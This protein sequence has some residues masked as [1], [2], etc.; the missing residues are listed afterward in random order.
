MFGKRQ[1]KPK[2]L[3]EHLECLVSDAERR[4]SLMSAD[5]GG[6]IGEAKA[7]AAVVQ[8]LVSE[9]SILPVT[10]LLMLRDYVSSWLEGVRDN[11]YL[12]AILPMITAFTVML[13]APF[14]NQQAEVFAYILVPAGF[15]IYMLWRLGKDSK[16]FKMDRAQGELLLTVICGLLEGRYLQPTNGILEAATAKRAQD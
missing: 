7:R 6:L 3:F 2:D 13:L 10:D 1:A 16:E 15:W 8:S 4:V 14:M 11:S 5:N 12:N 9:L